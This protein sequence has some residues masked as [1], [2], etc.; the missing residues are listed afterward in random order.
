MLDVDGQGN[1]QHVKIFSLVAIFIILIACINF[2][3]LATAVSGQRAKE[4]GLRK[5]V[6][7]LR[8]QLITQF[9]GESMLLSFISLLLALAIV[10]LALQ[11]SFSNSLL[12][13]PQELF[14][15]D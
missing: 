10:Y 5:T 12:F 6:G 13:S 1:S 9:I 2:M 11:P 15:D 4:V 8:L 14:Y 7:A 3:N